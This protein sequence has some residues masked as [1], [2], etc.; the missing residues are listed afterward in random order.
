MSKCKHNI[1]D[2]STFSWWAAWLNNNLSK[3][4]IA[5]EKWMVNDNDYHAKIPESW[6]RFKNIGN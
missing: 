5:P 3:I 1:I 2:S 6:I 4:V